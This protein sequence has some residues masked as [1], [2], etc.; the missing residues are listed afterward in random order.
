MDKSRAWCFTVNNYTNE[1]LEEMKA[2][3]CT[4]IVLGKEVGKSG[5]PHIQGYVEFMNPRTFRAIK[6]VMPTA[7]IEPRKGTSAQAADYCKKDKDVY[8]SGTISQQG[9]RNDIEEIR[10]MVKQ[11]KGM[12]QILEVATTVPS[13]KMAETYLKYHEKGRDWKP[14]VKWYWGPTGTGKS[15]T[16][17]EEMPEAFDCMETSKWWEGY[18]SHPDVII[19]DMRGDFAKFHVLLKLLDRYPFRI[20]CKNGSR[21]FLARRIIIT[22]SQS[23][24]QMWNGRTTEDLMQLLRRINEIRFFDGKE[25]K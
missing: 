16:A 1:Q 13:V 3:E 10:N 21:Q 7:H 14:E 4:Y 22:S 11:G 24:Q 5:T 15:R 17:W 23:P 8:E 2:I 25:K 9:K 12:R 20:E 18:D 6:K 19:D